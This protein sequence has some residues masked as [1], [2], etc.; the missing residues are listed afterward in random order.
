MASMGVEMHFFACQ[1]VLSTDQKCRCWL[2][3]DKKLWALLLG[4][5]MQTW[6]KM[7]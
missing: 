7:V 1:L 2:V 5:C 4:S 3:G 6:V